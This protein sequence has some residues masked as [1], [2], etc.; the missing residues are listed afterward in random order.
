MST[1][2][3]KLNRTESPI[4]G[5]NEHA[6]YALLEKVDNEVIFVNPEINS[7]FN[8]K[9]G[10]RFDLGAFFNPTTGS[11]DVFHIEKIKT[12]GRA[13]IA[14]RV[15]IGDRQGRKYR[16]IHIKGVGYV[17]REHKYDFSGTPGIV[18]RAAAEKEK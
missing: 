12:H 8:I 14:G 4:Q 6:E 18:N 1:E 16:D 5:P 9:E 2:G 11:E 3:F 15:I 17:S 13:G 10:Q 7:P